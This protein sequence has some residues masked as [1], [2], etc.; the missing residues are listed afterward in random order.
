MEQTETEFWTRKENIGV[1][2]RFFDPLIL[3]S[4]F[5]FS[6]CIV[7][8]ISLKMDTNFLLIFTL[9]ASYIIF[10][11]LIFY[12]FHLMKLF[13]FLE[14]I[15][16]IEYQ[17]YIKEQKTIRIQQKE[18]TMHFVLNVILISIFIILVTIIL[19][20]II[21][22]V[23]P[24]IDWKAPV[25]VSFLIGGGS[26]IGGMQILLNRS[27]IYKNNLI[28]VGSEDKKRVNIEIRLLIG[29]GLAYL[30]IG[31]LYMLHNHRIL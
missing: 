25:L 23:T 19:L 2:N 8:L 18:K 28:I 5:L 22:W 6:F 14:K 24:T 10:A 29:V 26:L 27:F 21:E 3:I 7:I 12:H 20:L 31:L 17:E 1:I 16:Y 11:L 30:I 13:I 9:F 15:S 4:A